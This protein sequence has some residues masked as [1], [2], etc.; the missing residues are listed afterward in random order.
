[1][2]GRQRGFFSRLWDAIAHPQKWQTPDVVSESPILPEPAPVKKAQPAKKAPAKRAPA[3][4]APA[5][6]APAK[7]PAPAPQIPTRQR[8]VPRNALPASWGPNKAALWQE[9]TRHMPREAATDWEIQALYDAALYSFSEAH[10]DRKAIQDELF[11][12]IFEKYG[13]DFRLVFDW[14]GYREA[15]DSV[16]ASHDFTGGGEL[17]T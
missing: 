5:K 12:M 7:R 17:D 3:K 11:R 14:Q 2:P 4:K 6:R 9:A 13:V 1:M 8:I 15:Y 10:E 16:A